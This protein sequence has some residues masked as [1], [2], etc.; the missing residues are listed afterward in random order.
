MMAGFSARFRLAGLLLLCYLSTAYAI[1]LAS[2]CPHPVNLPAVCMEIS[3]AQGISCAVG[4]G[5]NAA[6][7][8]A[9]KSK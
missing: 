5:Y 1:A 8:P 3:D 6:R 7:Q 4:C 2:D 9:G